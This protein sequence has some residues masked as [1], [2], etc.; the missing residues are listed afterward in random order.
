MSLL[1]T[2]LA[3]IDIIAAIMIALT[4]F[5]YIGWFKWIV[6]VALLYMGITS[7]FLQPS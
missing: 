2:F 5:A 3:I 1:G 7:L 4:D 6:V